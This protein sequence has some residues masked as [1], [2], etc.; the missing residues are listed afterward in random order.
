MEFLEKLRQLKT[1]KDDHIAAMP[2]FH[3]K[4]G[5]GYI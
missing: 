2:T 5:K 1:I 4:I 3:G